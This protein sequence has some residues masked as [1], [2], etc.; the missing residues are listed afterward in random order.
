MP[1]H[2]AIKVMSTIMPEIDEGIEAL[3][4]KVPATAVAMPEGRDIGF[5]ERKALKVIQERIEEWQRQ[6]A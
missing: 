3:I 4:D 6:L 5:N 2:S 1:D